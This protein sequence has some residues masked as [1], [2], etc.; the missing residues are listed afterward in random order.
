[1]STEPLPIVEAGAVSRLTDGTGVS[2]LTGSKLV[3]DIILDF[4]LALP[5][6]LIAINVASLEAATVA[7]VALIFAIGDVV[8]RVVY[9]ALLRW[10]QTPS[11]IG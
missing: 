5:P 4:L 1:M 8:F 10:A 11:T 2:Q 3:K 7:P 9:R 6:A